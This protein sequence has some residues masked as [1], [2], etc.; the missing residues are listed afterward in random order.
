[1]NTSLE[2]EIPETEEVF[3]LTQ[4]PDDLEKIQ[5]LAEILKQE[6]GEIPVLIIGKEYQVNEKGLECLKLN[7]HP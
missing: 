3:T 5:L 7:F 2:A 1:M 6:L 4:L